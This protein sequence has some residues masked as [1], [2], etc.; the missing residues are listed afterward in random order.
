MQFQADENIEFLHQLV[1]IQ[2]EDGELTIIEVDWSDL[3]ERW[4]E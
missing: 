4:A 2:T 1:L 3:F